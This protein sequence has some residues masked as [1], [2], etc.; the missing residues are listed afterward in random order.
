MCATSS[1]QCALRACSSHRCVAVSRTFPRAAHGPRAGSHN[2]H[3]GQHGRPNRAQMVGWHPR[4]TICCV[5]SRSRWACG[6]IFLGSAL[7]A[8]S[9]ASVTTAPPTSTSTPNANRAPALSLA[10]LRAQFLA[11]ETTASNVS[12]Q[13][14]TAIDRLPSDAPASAL[15][16]AAA[17]IVS[18]G[19]AYLTQ[20]QHLPWPTNMTADAKALEK[21]LSR[22]IELVQTARNVCEGVFGRNLESCRISPR[23]SGTGNQQASP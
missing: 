17:P 8:C 19:Q 4:G 14:G 11:D 6:I 5:K 15:A 16:A 10:E 2:Q 22:Y 23:I 1:H 3:F 12:T 20:L 7:A 18:G 21:E 13:A 9:S